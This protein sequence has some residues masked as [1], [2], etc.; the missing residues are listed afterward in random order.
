MPAPLVPRASTGRT[1][2]DD[3]QVVDGMVDKIR[4]GIPG[5]DL[6]ECYGSWQTVYA[7]LRRYALDGVFTRAT[8][9]VVCSNGEL[10][11]IGDG[12]GCTADRA[13]PHT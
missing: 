13:T 7:R 6:P 4:T 9:N 5:R 3:R 8:A 11:C 12:V 2:A 1:R 10:R